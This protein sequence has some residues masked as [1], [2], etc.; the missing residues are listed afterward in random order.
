MVLV[1]AFLAVPGPGHSLDIVIF[2]NAAKGSPEE[3]HAVEERVKGD[4][5]V[6]VRIHVHNV[7]ISW[8]D[9]SAPIDF[10]SL[11]RDIELSD[12]VVLDNMGPMPIPFVTEL[13]ERVLGEPVSSMQEFFR[14]LS[15]RKRLVAMITG[16]QHDLIL[17]GPGCRHIV[18]ATAAVVNLGFLFRFSSDLT[19]AVEFLVW[20]ADPSIP[21]EKLR[22]SDVR[23]SFAAVYVP[24]RGWTFPEI[25]GK[26]LEESYHRW[27]HALEGQVRVNEPLWT[28]VRLS[29]IPSWVKAIKE[30]SSRFFR[31]LKLP[32][33]RIVVVLGYIDALYKGER[34]LVEEITEAIHRE[35][36]R[37]FRDVTTVAILCDGNVI[38][39]V[40]VLLR[41][42]DAG[43]DIAAVVS[44]W[45][46]TL[47]YPNPGTWAL[48]RIDAPVIKVVYPFWADWMDEPQRYLNMEEGGPESG[49]MG[50]LFEWG[51]QVIGGPEPEGAFWFKMV[52]L[53]ERDRM[54]VFP[55]K[56]MVED[57][58]RTVVKFLRLRYLP[59]SKKRVAFVLY[60]YPPGRGEIGASYLDVFRSLVRIFEALAERG[61]DLGPA[62]TLY[63]KLAELRRKDPKAAEEMEKRLA[64]ALMAASDLVLKNVG[65][66]AKGELADMVRLYR[67]G[68]AEISV[69]WNGKEMKIIVDHG[70][71]RWVD[72]DGSSYVLGTVGPEQ[73]VPVG[74]LERWY[75]ED[76]LRRFEY[77][78]SLLTGND[79]QTERAR[80]SL[81]KWMRAV[82][83]KFG[84][85]SDNRGIMRYG[86][87]YVIPALRL[88]NVVVMLQPVRGWSGSPELVYHS[89]DLPPQWQYIAAYE[90]LRRVFH[91]DAI[92]HVGTHG[93]LEWLPGH[94]VGLLGVDWPHILLPD[95]PH[96]YIYIVSNPGEAMVAKYR[97]GPI[98]LTHLPPPWGYFK[99]LGKYGEL[100]R[101]LTRYFQMK[102]FGGDPRVLEELRRRIVDTAERLGL[103][104]PVVNM[105]ARER[106]EPPPA[107]PK[108]WALK[109]LEGFIDKL[110]DFLLDLA[111]R[112]VA[113]GLHVYGE[114]V[115]EDVAVEQAAALAS[116]RVAP[117]FAYYA[118]LIDSPDRTALDRLQSDAPDLF[119]RFKRELRECLRD[120]L[121]AV[122][123][124]PGLA[125]QLDRYVVLKDR[126]EYYGESDSI[127][128]PGRKAKHLFWRVSD[129][130]VA[131]AREAIALHL[132]G[133][134]NDPY[135]EHLLAEAVA[136]LYRIY[137]HYRDSGRTELENLLKSLDGRFVPPGLLGEPMWNTK[138]LPT[139]RDGYPID[140]SQMPTPEAWDV[141]RKLVD[142]M[143]ADY[144]RR[145]GRWPELVGVVLWGV[146]ELCTGG[147]TIAEILYLLG[148]RP[149]WNPDTG[150][151]IGV[152]LI[153][154]DELKV[155]VGNR[156]INRPRIDVVVWAALHMREPLELLTDAYRLVSCVDEPIEYN[157]RRKH[158]LEL[159]PRLE[160]EY[161]REGLSPEEAEKLADLVA[162]SGFF[163]Q[164]PGV[165][166]GTGACDIVE[167]AWTDVAGTVGLFED[168]KT[169]LRRFERS[170]WEKFMVA[171]ESRMAYVYAAEARILKIR[172]G[173]RVR[174][175]VLRTSTDRVYYAIPS[176]EAFRYLMS[177]VDIVVHNVVNTWGLL[178]TDDFYDWVG[179]MAL[180]AT[181]ASGHA[182]EVYIGNAVDPTAARMLTCY[183]QLVGEV[184]TKLLSES[185]WKAMLEHGDYGW[186]RIAKRIEYLAGWGITVPSLRP[187]LN[188]LYTK[189]FRII[190]QRITQTPPRTEYGWAAV[191]GAVAWFVELARTGVWEPDSKTLAQAAKILLELMAKHGPATCHHTSP[192]P[193]LVA[194]AVRVLLE[195]GYS[196]SE[197]QRLLSKLVK[198]YAKLDN[199]EIVRQIERLIRKVMTEAASGTVA[200]ESRTTGHV[201]TSR[202]ATASRS[203]GIVSRASSSITSQAISTVTSLTTPSF[204]GPGVPGGK[205][206][207]QTSVGLVGAVLHGVARGT[208]S[209]GCWS[210]FPRTAGHTAGRTESELKASRTVSKPERGVKRESRATT[211]T[212]TSPPSTGSRM[213][214]EWVAALLL[215]LLFLLAWKIR[216]TGP[217]PRAT[218][219][220]PATVPPVAA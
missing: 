65:P 199:P 134:R 135:H 162:S 52:A 39:P 165:Y 207:V 128:G 179:G 58:A 210:G 187:Y 86:S 73:L 180:Y 35:I 168:P 56:D 204:T 138:V 62:T 185:W 94:Q 169:A 89:P 183:Q 109:H 5:G 25:P 66:W 100:E 61:Y 146:H 104:E 3:I 188:S 123:R 8:S 190:A 124:N 20:L 67:G 53:K 60:C 98:L 218:W 41:L 219:I 6:D 172:E 17:P 28:E 33:R 108:E 15:G 12:I 18:D 23:A 31:P 164:P 198:W 78:L 96:I 27:L 107:N 113:Y 203:T 216:P 79:P 129:E 49:R 97:S 36:T 194:Y 44:L 71:V 88:G 84:S 171:C 145:Y 141:A 175:V 153:P 182:P 54:K 189:V 177:K 102:S 122:L 91:A 184:Y 47:D 159:K 142:Q 149:V 63:R 40:E 181:Y 103:L 106:N 101:E 26:L 74:T 191:V 202:G 30:A 43:Y 90:W 174:I 213:I 186:A 120:I 212:R 24:G 131:I 76:V 173:N 152:E 214:W 1:A 133:W 95:V 217:E 59:E 117:L 87:Y 200:V 29:A 4:L 81:M 105:I 197:V 92:V 143:L 127:G 192:N 119:A 211:L 57:L 157:Y 163:A 77:Y 9:Q 209:A 72:V 139:G 118:G 195:A 70:E 178:D 42:K 7:L 148:V 154:L 115:D 111:L 55:L 37:E 220:T 206:G 48:V 46:F 151:V 16:E 205:R 51:Y 50:A 68:R 45:A 13:S 150:Q 110:H 19:P 11:A 85:P 167:H 34:D 208:A 137:V 144:Y 2:G 166:T 132:H 170:F 160:E 64:H 215:T 93:T 193:A 22:L 80:E 38:S 196:P 136:D 126:E 161:R 14:R 114:D 75:R 112:N 130:L 116:S 32:G 83:E 121:R 99:D 155:K 147:L 140:P 82:E 125:H 69:D 201:T 176:V 156:W 21:A 158:Y 10:D